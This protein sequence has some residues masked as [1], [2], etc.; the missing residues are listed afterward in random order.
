[1]EGSSGYLPQSSSSASTSRARASAPAA[2]DDANHCRF[3]SSYWGFT[4][5]EVFTEHPAIARLGELLLFD[6]QLLAPH[7]T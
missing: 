3:H 2:R 6:G 4:P 7:F 5:D 1:M